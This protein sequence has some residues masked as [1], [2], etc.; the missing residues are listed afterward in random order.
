M[1]ELP[2]DFQ[3]QLGAGYVLDRELGRGGMATVYLA[4]DVKHGR[5]VALKVLHPG[6]AQSLGPERFRREIALAARLQHPHILSVYDSGETAGGQLWFTMPFVEGDTLRDRLRREHQLAMADALRLATEIADALEYAHTH[7]VL[8]RDIKPENILLSA[9]HALVADFGVARSVTGESSTRTGASGSL[10]GAGTIV[11]TPTYMSPEQASGDRTLDA[12]S[13][14]YSLAAVLYEMLAGEP[15]FS[16]PSPQAIIAKLMTSPAPSVRR[17]RPSVPEPIDAVLRQ[18]LA[19]VPSDRFPTAAEFARAL[20]AARQASVA[21]PALRPAAS[22]ADPT[23]HGRRRALP[24]GAVLLILGFLIGAG[25]L[26]AWRA[27][28]G[29]AGSGS[30]VRLAVLPFENLGDYADAYFADGVTDAVRD[31]LATLPTLQVIARASSEQ[32]RR[33]QKPPQVIGRELGAQYLLTATVRWEKT[34]GGSSRV[35]VRPELVDATTAAEKWGQPFDA[36]LTDVFAVQSDIAGKV[37][38]ALGVA[39]NPGTRQA[40][41]DRPTRNLDA[42]DA[43]LR[44][45]A[46]EGK[47]GVDVGSLRRATESYAQA[48]QLD[49]GFALAWA[50]L[51]FAHATAFHTAAPMAADSAASLTAATRALALGP[52]LPEAHAAMGAYD[53]FVLQDPGRALA[54]YDAG[55]RVTPHNALL[56]SQAGHAEREL[57]RWDAAVAHYT[58]AAQ[59]DPREARP[60]WELCRTLL[61]L[62]RLPEA[63]AAADRALTVSP[64]NLPAVDFRAMVSLA[65]G[66]LAGAQAVFRA[67]RED[68]DPRAIDAFVATYYDIAWALDSA[69]QQV[70]L[71]LDPSAYGGDRAQWVFVRAELYWLRGDRGHARAYADSARAAYDVQLRSEPRDVEGRVFDGLALAML[72]RRAD[73]LRN[74]AEV[75]QSAMWAHG[76]DGPYIQHQVARIYLILGEPDRAL[77]VLE[78]L[79]RVPYYLTPA[80]LAIDP[81]FAPLRG[82]PRFQAMLARRDVNP[83]EAAGR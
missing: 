37:A 78:G 81:T 12:R 27:R 80:W 3:T 10:T 34:A 48:V 83:G 28:T 5:L 20:D 58:E 31:K 77:D 11:G 35:Q 8:H 70:L 2:D 60:A 24:T 14:V 69:D 53:D 73:A 61:W 56:L 15:P 25:A 62:R 75:R 40:M 6:L 59:L 17:V 38:Q 7:G 45:Q 74:V 21:T 32:Y 54:E 18:A 44:G 49:S 33:T 41:A 42:Y 16:G 68:A 65:A 9:G 46:I 51:S 36:S 52:E 13:D 4:R 64:G 82:N 55:L 71:G 26:F 19:P 22:A 63:R 47:A 72:G 30:P 79:L 43:Y 23:A 76:F 1:A 66:D 29:E 50:A 57:D 67:A 39:L